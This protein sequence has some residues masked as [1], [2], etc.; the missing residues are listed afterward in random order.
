M[1]YVL[2]PLSPPHYVTQIS[3]ANKNQQNVLESISE[4]AEAGNKVETKLNLHLGGYKK[5]AE[6]LKKKI[7]EAH[8]AL[9]KANNALSSFNILQ[10]SEAAAI[11]NRLSALRAEVGVVST[12]EREAQELY[13]RTRE[14]LQELTINVPNG[15]H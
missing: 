13:R 7:G 14:E 12:R 8:E 11:R 3:E 5:R 10:I 2:T 15:Y 1:T 9:E 4:S 6:M